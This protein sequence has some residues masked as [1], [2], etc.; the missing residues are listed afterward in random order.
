MGSVI[1]LDRIKCPAGSHA[2]HVYHGFCRV[3]QAD[4]RRRLVSYEVHVPDETP[5]M[6]DL[7][8]GVSAKEVLFSEK[9]HVEEVWVDLDELRAVDPARDLIGGGRGRVVRFER[10]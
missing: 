6:T 4:G 3:L 10:K 9:I 8:D 2:L 1:V 5:D 7:P